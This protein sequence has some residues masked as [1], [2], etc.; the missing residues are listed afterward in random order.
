MITSK[1]DIDTYKLISNCINTY[2]YTIISTYI[3]VS[4]YIFRII[5]LFKFN[6]KYIIIQICKTFISFLL[7]L[8][9]IFF[10]EASFLTLK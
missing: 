4:K 7:L 6:K 9:N 8:K 2:N 1:Y 5:I 3:F 10:A